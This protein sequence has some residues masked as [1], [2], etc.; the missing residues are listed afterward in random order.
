MP[1]T[2]Y[3]TRRIPEIG[4]TMLRE[5]G[6]EVDISSF[7]RPLT[8]DELI[9]I[10]KT[11][12]YDAVLSLITDEIDASVMDASP[13][14][15][16]FANFAIGF[17]NFTIEDAKKRGVF[18]SN[19]PGAGAER[20]AEHAWAFI[21]ALACRIVEA[22]IFVKAGKYTGWD[23][24]LFHGI[25][26]AGK[27]LGI[28]G[29][30]KIGADVV[31]RGKNGFQMNVVYYDINRNENLEKEFGA[32]FCPTVEEVL[33][34]ADVVSL[35][36][37]LTPQTTHLINADRLKLMKKTA[38]IVN[39][40]RGPV[41]DEVA[42][43]DALQKGIIAGAGLDV[44]EFEPKLAPGLAELPNVILTPHIASATRESREDMAIKAV[45][46]IIDVMEGGKPRNLVYN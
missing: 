19:A 23:P 36:V 22:D 8:K 42:L 43:V 16:I 15:K 4:I 41:I 3:V 24:M 34:V 21:T 13:S 40:S 28:I 12:P 9:Q 5:K 32:T 18:L 2:I 11:K 25:Q 7:D 31:R 46:N 45:T 10:L 20:V 26:L 1:K 6:Y 29:T 39:T 37:P 44:F 35:H 33:K 17:N 38:F 14:T 30:G 27:T